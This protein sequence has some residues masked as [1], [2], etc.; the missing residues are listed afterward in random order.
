MI[1]WI[2]SEH[3]QGLGAPINH[4]A[5]K[6]MVRDWDGLLCHTTHTTIE[7]ARLTAQRSGNTSATAD[8]LL[9]NLTHL[10]RVTR[11]HPLG[12]WHVR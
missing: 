6:R 9:R 5:M 4:R 2:T 12:T 3:G 10:S 7:R 11:E 8:A 1:A